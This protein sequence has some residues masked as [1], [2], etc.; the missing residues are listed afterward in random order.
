[1]TSGPVESGEDAAAKPERCSYCGCVLAYKASYTKQ[2]LATPRQQK[3]ILDEVVAT[4]GWEGF[5]ENVKQRLAPYGYHEAWVLKSMCTGCGGWRLPSKPEYSQA[6]AEAIAAERSRAAET[7]EARHEAAD[8][9]NEV[10]R[11]A[12][13]DARLFA[14]LLLAR[15]PEWEPYVRFVG[16]QE[17]GDPPD[18][19]QWECALEARV[20]CPNPAVAAPLTIRVLGKQVLPSWFGGWHEHIERGDDAEPGDLTHL[21]RAL[22]LVEALVTER[23]AV[24]S[25]YRGDQLIAGGDSRAGGTLPSE[26][27]ATIAGAASDADREVWRSWRGTH[28]REIPLTPLA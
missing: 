11:R 14:E 19:L 8:W 5:R 26:R 15:F 4:H 24:W 28:D 25:R 1:M 23:M 6:E 16:P 18:S 2:S 12:K 20:P 17:P 13:R 21:R 9:R 10:R 3:A 7:D 22:E 27:F